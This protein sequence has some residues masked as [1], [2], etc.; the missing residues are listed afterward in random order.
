M[1]SYIVHADVRCALGDDL[2]QA[3][4]NLFA[5]RQPLQYRHF[6]EL[7]DPVSLP[8]F[9]AAGLNEAEQELR[10]YR[11]L[12]DMLQQ[13]LERHPLSEQERQRSGIFIG[14]SSFDINVSERI[15]AQALGQE[16]DVPAHAL[17]LPII[18]YGK[19]A[20]SLQAEFALGPHAQ[21]HSTACTSSANALLNAHRMLQA[22]VI[23]HAFVCGVE[24][25][26][27]T[28]LLGFH[29][30][31]LI[32]PSARMSPFSANRDGLILGEGCGLVMLSKA[33]EGAISLCGGA[34]A[35][36]NHSLTAAN[37]DGSTIAGVMAEALANCQITAPQLK[38][39][40]LHGTASLM[41]DEAEA[42]GIRRLLSSLP[43]LF[44]LKPFIGHTLGACGVLEAA[45]VVGC[46]Q[47]GQLPAS[48]DA[49]ATDEQLGLTL[50]S[51]P[52]IAAPGYYGLNYFAFGGNNA[53]LILHKA[54]S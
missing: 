41:N 26:N 9:A 34:I 11:F 12:S 21:T 5:G 38:G 46:L 7:D 37:S 25:F 8:Y 36:D 14:S 13:A 52:E 42:A 28:T 18:G 49:D 53:C 16:P 47:R 35:T 29:G 20:A 4:D 30:L 23:D 50:L 32:S 45:L 15:Y 1:G 22:G 3:M 48:P 54:A 24:F 39:L 44:A 6:G 33:E 43:P 10:V 51:Q 2:D 40:K 27:Q 17:P 31:G 19:I